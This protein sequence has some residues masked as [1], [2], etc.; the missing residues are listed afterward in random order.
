LKFQHH[1]SFHTLILLTIKTR[2]YFAVAEW[3]VGFE[4]MYNSL[5]DR[6]GA[7]SASVEIRGWEGG[8]KEDLIGFIQRKCHVRLQNVDVSGPILSAMVRPDE[9]Q[10]LVK[11]SGVRFAGSPLRIAI[12]ENKN[13]SNSTPSTIEILRKFL[14]TRY[15]P[16]TLLLDLQ[17]MR[18]DQF[19]VENGLFATASTSSKMF[20]ALMK[21]AD[22]QVTA[23]ESVNLAGNDLQDVAGVTTLAQTYPDLKNLSLADNNLA[24]INN[25]E[26]WR[27]KFKN[28]GQLILTGNPIT[29]Q[30]SYKEDIMR[31]FPRLVMLDGVIV[32]D[33]SQLAILRL[34]Q[35]VKHMFFENPDIQSVVTNF[36]TSYV[37]LFDRDRSQLLQ[38]YDDT[39]TFSVSMDSS[40]PRSMI[41]SGRVP[42]WSPYISISRNLQKVS[43]P[44]ARNVRLAV[45]PQAI[46][47]AFGRIPATKHDLVQSPHKFSIEAWRT[48]GV[49]TADDTGIITSLHGEFTEP[50]SADTLRSFDRV[51]VLT[52]GPTGNMIVAA[53]MLTVRAWAGFDAWKERPSTQ[54]STAPSVSGDAVF[55]GLDGLKPDQIA[56]VQNLMQE[57]RL[58]ARYA[59]MCA[60]QAQFD[61][62]QAATLFQQSRQQLPPEAFI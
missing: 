49:R 13:V 43:T 34:P 15:N 46:S 12:V 22:E 29:Q 62:T 19:L 17:N 36:L 54:V 48:T 40:C 7:T 25:L 51:F 30:V 50:Q 56:I 60:E 45:G 21:V 9:A 28:L 26:Q 4:A 6:I 20:P 8:T 53:D 33:E 27:H 44:T 18:G 2:R 35:P 55:T 14:A 10:P 11:W 39:S 52:Q 16:N 47:K 37:D 41:Q 38:L 3:N 31:M 1:F 58:N 24:R 57:T 5:S 61:I 59:R 32:R 42:N 23:V